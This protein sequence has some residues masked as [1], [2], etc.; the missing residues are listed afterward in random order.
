[1]KSYRGE[2]EGQ[3]V[4][5]VTGA[6]S[7]I[8]RAIGE[9]LALEGWKVYGAARS[10]VTG[11]DQP[12][13]AVQTEMERG[14]VWTAV[15]LDVTDEAAFASAVAEIV[16][17][18][19]RLDLLVQ[20]AGSGLAGAIE[21][22]SAEEAR[23]QIDSL[24]FGSAVGLRPILAQMRA[25]GGGRIVQIGSL[26][27]L[28][29]IPFQ[30]WYSAGKA[31]VE[32]LILALDGEVRPFGIRCMLV[33]PG[34]TR[35]GFSKAR[36]IAAACDRQSAYW[37]RCTRSV[38]K[39]EQD[40]ASGMSSEKLA[41]LVVRQLSRKRPPLIFTPGWSSRLTAL[42]AKWLPLRLVRRLVNR[43]YAA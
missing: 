4:A 3:P 16:S 24:L 10:L 22:C 8:G 9:R 12:V 6:S 2:R 40:E 38:S 29:P 42:A 32:A 21:D 18:E 30:G 37:Q 13:T 23:A 15:R 11:Q 14:A 36:R 19:G 43:L 17:R 33:Q 27:G 31:A 25:Q 7:G 39:M 34:D 26:A 1:M 41:A 28:L 35:S 20:S 5:L